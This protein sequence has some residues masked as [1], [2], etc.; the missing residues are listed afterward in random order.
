MKKMSMIALLLVAVLVTSYSVSGT[1]AKYTSTFVGSTDSARVAAWSFEVNDTD[2]TVAQNAFTFNLFNTVKDTKDG[3]AESDVKVGNQQT[4]EVIIAPGTTGS[5]DIKL[6]NLSEVN[7]KYAINYTLT[8]SANIPVEF[9][10]GTVDENTEWVTNIASLNVSEVGINMNG[11]AV[12]TVNWRWAFVG[13]E[14]TNFT[15][16][17]TDAT[18]TA[19]GEKDTLDTISVQASIIV[20]Q[21]D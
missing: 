4:D 12:V 13:T 6:E 1:Y 8:N 16:S 11:E 2:M 10:I 19:L 18:D 15:T 3:A 5:F 20:T 7:A 17:Q 14:S 9:S 21:V